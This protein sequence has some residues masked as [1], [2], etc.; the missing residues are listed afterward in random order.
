MLFQFTNKV[1]SYIKRK[2]LKIL[3]KTNKKLD[4]FFI[5][6]LYSPRK[7]SLKHQK[8]NKTNILILVHHLSNGGAE[9]VVSHLCDEFSKKYN[10][11]LVNFEKEKEIDYKCSVK[12]IIINPIIFLCKFRTINKLK[13][14]KKHYNITH[15]ISFGTSI[16]YYNTMS[17]VND[18][19]IISVRNYMSKSIKY[20]MQKSYIEEAV[21][22]ADKIIAVSDMVK[23]DLIRTFNADEKK[24]SII[25][26]YCDGEKI[27]NFLKDPKEI[28]M[29]EKVVI[30]VGRLTYQK[31]QINLIKAFKQVVDKIPDAKLIILGQ[32]PLKNEL[33]E[34]ILNLG[35]KDNIFLY[36]FKV[37]PYIYLKNSSIFV[38]SSLYEGMSNALLEAM[39]CGLPIIATD[40]RA[41]VREILAPNTNFEQ[42]NTNVTYEEHGVLVP[43]MYND[44]NTEFMAEA[45]IK[46][47]QNDEL[48]QSYSIKSKDRIKD[49][50]KEKILKKWFKIIE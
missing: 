4:S 16:N 46:M 47:L 38:L 13:K 22:Y 18:T 11:I 12:R 29:G 2:V 24:I 35:L 33:N 1:I 7:K 49:F 41:G 42:Y 30:N 37:N 14:I 40:C 25:Y 21:K 9:R 48:R 45:I 10:V 32:G 43:V 8:N 39:Y 3:K 31:C 19:T 6:L 28:N 34:E 44:S 15:S 20:E 26:N 17:K 50:Y 27:D 5:K 36:G 23:Y